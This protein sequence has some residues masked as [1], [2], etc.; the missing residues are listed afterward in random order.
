MLTWPIGAGN[1]NTTTE[2]PR[3]AHTDYGYDY[4][5]DDTENDAGSIFQCRNYFGQNYNYF[6]FCVATFLVIRSWKEGYPY[7][8]LFH[9]FHII[10]HTTL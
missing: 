4:A 6:F 5:Y 7:F 10:Y 2:I 8:L 9:R 1:I 3:L